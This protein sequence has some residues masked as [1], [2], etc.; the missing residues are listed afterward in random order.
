MS[1]KDQSGVLASALWLKERGAASYGSHETSG[2]LANRVTRPIS[3]EWYDGV[4]KDGTCPRCD[5]PLVKSGNPNGGVYTACSG[6][7]GWKCYHIGWRDD[8]DK[9]EERIALGSDAEPKGEE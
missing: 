5:A 8:E 2:S 6:D 9:G 1:L 4:L 3:R 7:D